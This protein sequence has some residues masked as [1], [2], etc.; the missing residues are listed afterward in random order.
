MKRPFVLLV[1]PWITDFAAFDLWSKPLGLLYIGALLKGAGIDVAL[2]DCLERNSNS[3]K[4]KGIIPGKEK[5]FGTGKFDKRPIEKPEP[6]KSIP[7]RYFIYGITEEALIEK[8]SNLWRKPDLILVTSIMTYWHPGVR[9]T[10]RAI[11]KRLPSVPLW[12]GGIY[13]RLCYEHA[14]RT[15]GADFV[16][17]RPISHL[18]ELL[19]K[20]LGTEI[21][22]KREWTNFTLFPSPAWELMPKVKYRVLLTS[23]GCPFKCSYCASRILQPNQEYRPFTLLLSEILEGY[24]SGIRDFAFYDD[25]LLFTGWQVVKPLLEEIRKLGISV[26]FHTPNALHVRALNEKRCE[27]LFSGGFK[28]IRLGLE[29]TSKEHQKKWGQ[30]AENKEFT[31]VAKLLLKTGWETKD[32]GAYLLCGV[33]GQKPSEVKDSIDFVADNGILPFIAEFSP[34]PKTKIWNEAK[35]ISPFDIEKEPLYHNNSFF[36]CRRSDFTYEDMVSLKN[37][38]RRVRGLLVTS[39]KASSTDTFSS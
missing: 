38:A 11:K 36:A 13:A 35:R 19:E 21:Q 26:R 2:I 25:A 32:I 39:S 20:K 23:V 17:K 24:Q 28:T 10:I 15:S 31:R 4:T 14:V 18:P 1:N 6:Y 37:Y 5:Q 16:I 9:E 12:L 27:L 7:R 29:T 34:I 3:E 22:N 8:I 33:P 30:K